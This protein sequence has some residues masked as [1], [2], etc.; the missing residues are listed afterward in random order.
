MI[1]KC[2]ICQNDFLKKTGN[3]ITCSKECSKLQQKNNEKER[4]KDPEYMKLFIE[5]KKKSAKKDYL[6]HI[7][8]C[9]KNAMK[10]RYTKKC[11]LCEK[12]FKTYSKTVITCSDAC[13]RERMSK[14]RKWEN[15]PAF[16]NWVYSKQSNQKISIHHFKEREF[17]KVCKEIDDEMLRN[18]WY[19]F[20]EFC[21]V[22]NSPRWEH[23]HIV[24]R[25]EKPRHEHIH[26]KENIINLCI[27]NRRHS[28]RVATKFYFI[29]S[30]D[31]THI[32][33]TKV[34]T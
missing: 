32:I 31:L 21:F 9:K 27:C 3:Q 1:V 14:N 7:E 10:L 6:K 23:H 20:C 4:K 28:N 11:V 2:L 24:F 17:T 18:Y 25:S 12:E 8:R 15:N 29:I 5:K 16:R 26:A 30:Q 22:N 19:R 13:Y 34:F 33:A